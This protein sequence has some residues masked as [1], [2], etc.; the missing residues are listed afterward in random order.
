MTKFYVL[1]SGS[2]NS[3]VKTCLPV[4]ARDAKQ[5]VKIARSTGLYPYGVTQGKRVS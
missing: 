2:L 4:L 3:T 1:C 5:A